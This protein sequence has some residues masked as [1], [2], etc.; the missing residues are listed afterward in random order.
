MNAGIDLGLW[1]GSVNLVVDVFKEKRDDIFMQRKNVPGSAGFNRPVWA[2][3]G[4]V[5]NQGFDVSLN[6]NHKFNSDWAISAMANYTYAHNKVVEIDEP[7]AIL[8]TYRSQTGKPVGQLFGLIAER[9]F[10]EDDFDENGML[11]EGIP[12]QKFSDMSNLRPGDIKYKDLNGDGEVT[13]VD[14]TAIGGTRIP[15]I[16]YGFGATVSYKSFDLGVFFQGTG[17][18]YQLLGGETWL[19]GSSL[20]AGNIYSNIDNRWTP[21]N[22]RQDVF[23]PRMGD[24]AVANNEQASTWWLRDMSFLRLKNLELGY[25]LPQRWT[26]KIGIRSCRLFARGTNLLTFSDFKLWDPELET[27]DGL[28]YPQMKSVSVGFSINFNN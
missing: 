9:L 10:T 14:A 21:E 28:R 11:K 24:K 25:T 12:A 2:N 17:K 18:T 22:P 20:G 8:D 19:P 15:E 27:T 6:V 16:V 4:K 23:W 3:Y 26:T 7:A 5:D 13:S 1:N